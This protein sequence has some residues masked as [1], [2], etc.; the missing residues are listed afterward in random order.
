[1]TPSPSATGAEN[2]GDLLDVLEVAADAR[3]S[4]T[5]LLATVTQLGYQAELSRIDG[6]TYLTRWSADLVVA[7]LLSEGRA[8]KDATGVSA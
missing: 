1:M 2:G 7:R 4:L 6:T 8:K 3:V 5:G